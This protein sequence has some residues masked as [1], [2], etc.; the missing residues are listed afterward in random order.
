MDGNRSGIA[1]ISART[2]YRSRSP[3]SRI[4]ANLVTLGVPMCTSR[5]T[6]FPLAQV[7]YEV[8]AA[9]CTHSLAHRA[10]ANQPKLPELS[11]NYGVIVQNA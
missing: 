5:S 3:V 8:L 9:C 10:L 11:L 2:A 1:T 4:G 6:G 7:P